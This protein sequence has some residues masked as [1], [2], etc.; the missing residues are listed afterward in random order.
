MVL[1]GHH[2]VSEH[3]VE[4]LLGNDVFKSFDKGQQS[5]V[6]DAH[7]HYETGKYY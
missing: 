6:A 4:E 2:N 5:L 1:A 7:I 3:R